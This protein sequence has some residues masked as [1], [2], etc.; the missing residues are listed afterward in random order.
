[1]YYTPKTR[2]YGADAWLMGEGGSEG[3]KQ[4]AEA[5]GTLQR[6]EL[7][8][9]Q[10][11]F[12]TG[13]E[14]QLWQGIEQQQQLGQ[15]MASRRGYNPLA[16]RAAGMAGAEMESQGY[17][18]AQQLRAAQEA[19]RR[20]EVLAAQQARSQY[21]QMMGQ[22]GTQVFQAGMEDSLRREGLR[23]GLA[24]EAR[25]RE[26]E[27][28]VGTVNAITG[29]VSGMAQ[30]ASDEN[31]KV[32]IV[33]AGEAMD[34]M[35]DGGFEW[36]EEKFG[37][38]PKALEDL[39]A[40]LGGSGV[41]QAMDIYGERPAQFY[42]RAG[43]LQSGEYGNA[44][45][46]RTALIYT[47]DVDRSRVGGE[48]SPFEQLVKGTLA[49]PAAAPVA[50]A[51]SPALGEF[52]QTGFTRQDIAEG[53]PDNAITY[54]EATPRPV[55]QGVTTVEEVR[56]KQPMAITV[57]RMV[58]SAK[59]EA[60]PMQITPEMITEAVQ[61]FDQ[62]TAKAAPP[63]R[64]GV[65]TVERATPR[66]IV[67]APD[68]ITAK[69]PPSAEASLRAAEAKAQEAKYMAAVNKIA[70]ATKKPA[71]ATAQQLIDALSETSKDVE[72]Q[73]RDT[74]RVN[75]EQ[76][77]GGPSPFEAERRQLDKTI[78]SIRPF[79]YMYDTEE[80]LKA[81]RAGLITPPGR[82]VGFMAQDLAKTPLGAQ[83][84]EN[85]S[86]GLGVDLAEAARLS[87][88]LIGRIGQRLKRLESKNG[89][90]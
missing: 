19:Q 11:K 15:S 34:S 47:G 70:E 10:S 31:M 56:G 32:G 68:T 79:S 78:E 36:D 74:G 71:E 16:A 48:P 49:A 33:P 24:A 59:P 82:Q 1:M 18:A 35:I 26:R 55:R 30:V 40:P 54:V 12:M 42:G 2:M 50:V 38:K 88:P 43:I 5:M 28:D 6:P 44:E 60:A 9:G 73:L 8:P 17:G 41:K 81:N 29:L 27:Q 64:R 62:P 63:V 84:V 80:A 45:N 13:A 51:A 52:R 39:A 22:L 90:E 53:G 89:G 3:D 61:A 76:I 83:A 72:Q 57:P 66:E 25:R 20:G 65:T 46:P 75:V 23:E 21:D 67:F 87:L 85:T 77:L 4:F 7:A 14:G 69:A 37:P 58:I 86:A